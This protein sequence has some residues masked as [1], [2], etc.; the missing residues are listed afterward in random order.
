MEND[1][2]PDHMDEENPYRY[3]GNP[4]YDAKGEFAVQMYSNDKKYDS[5]T[6]NYDS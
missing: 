4:C 2:V 6:P 5:D 1:Y 3:R